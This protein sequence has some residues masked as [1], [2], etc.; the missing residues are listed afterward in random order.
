M[1]AQGQVTS[2]HTH[3][4]AYVNRELAYA[5][6]IS[7]ESA[8]LY[9]RLMDDRSDADYNVEIFDQAEAEKMLEGVRLFNEAIR[10]ILGMD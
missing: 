2:K 5:G 7:K 4:R 6:L 9:N 1:I 8:K 3:A 10:G